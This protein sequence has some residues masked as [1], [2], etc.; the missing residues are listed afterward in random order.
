MNLTCRPKR[1]TND[2]PRF[3][4]KLVV[5][6]IAIPIDNYD[7]PHFDGELTQYATYDA[8]PVFNS[9]IGSIHFPRDLMDLVLVV[10]SDSHFLGDRSFVLVDH[11]I[12]SA[13]ISNCTRF[14]SCRSEQS[15]R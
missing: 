12:S 4:A 2:V 11:P 3:P 5:G 8:V 6:S 13:G 15:F 9:T 7:K 10:Y 14:V 1:F